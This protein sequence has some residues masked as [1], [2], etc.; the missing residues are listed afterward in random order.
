MESRLI[1]RFTGR[2]QGVGFRATVAKYAEDLGINGFIRNEP[3]G[4]V[5]LDVDGK[6]EDLRSLLKRV[7]DRP[8]GEIEYADAIWGGSLSRKKGFSVG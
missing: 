2:I 8:A 3:D 4:S 7:Q 6:K 5:M 1:C